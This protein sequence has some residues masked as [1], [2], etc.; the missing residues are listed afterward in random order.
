MGSLEATAFHQSKH[1]HRG[2]HLLGSWLAVTVPLSIL[3]IVVGELLLPTLFGAQT[4]EAVELGRLYL[5]MVAVS[6]VTVVFNG[7]LLGDQRFLA[8]NSVRLLTPALSAVGYVT[9]LLTHELSVQLA[10]VVVAGATTISGIVA[11]VLCLKRHGLARPE[12]ALT[13]VTVWYGMRAHSGSLAG[14]VNARLDL[15]IIPA[16]LAA[17]SVGLYS[18]A[19]NVSSIIGTLTDT[20]ALVVL[21]IAARES[22]QSSQTV[23]KTL[24]AVLLIGIVLAGVLMV[25]AEVALRLVYGAE[26]TGAATALRIL[27]PGEVLFAAAAVLWSGL[28]AADRPTLSSLAY[29][30]AAVIT[31]VGLLLF[32]SSGGID[33]AATVTTCAYTVSFLCS[34]V[35]FKHVHSLRWRQFLPFRTADGS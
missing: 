31:V 8:Y 35:L 14:F 29:I 26:F 27:L 15:L 11:A 24:H 32:L 1:P 33:T 13:R 4:E 28:L 12:R 6:L 10:L 17:A 34:V 3:A 20:I 7:V 9:L 2:A 16:F 30:P 22:E 19:T 25:L 5:P 23:I 21:P 18:V